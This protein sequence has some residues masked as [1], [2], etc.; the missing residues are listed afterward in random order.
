MT[1]LILEGGKEN[2][3][4][5]GDL[6]ILCY[7]CEGANKHSLRQRDI[8]VINEKKW[9]TENTHISAEIIPDCYQILQTPL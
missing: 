2:V 3:R 6:A 9:N 8:K 1:A 7:S 4:I 5:S